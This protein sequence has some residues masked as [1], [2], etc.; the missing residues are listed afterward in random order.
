MVHD[1]T[2]FSAF[3][4]SEGGTYI[5]NKNACDC[6]VRLAM[7][8]P[9]DGTCLIKTS[10]F[11]VKMQKSSELQAH[12]FVTAIKVAHSRC[13]CVRDT[14]HPHGNGLS[15]S[16]SYGLGIKIC[17]NPPSIAVGSGT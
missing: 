9:T 5:G 17:L 2:A 4:L 13:C 6:V 7:Q 3:K 12:A 10:P 15:S 16:P 14:F 8:A 11:V 1:K